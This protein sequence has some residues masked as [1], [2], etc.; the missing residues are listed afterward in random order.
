MITER[1]EYR[2]PK[3]ISDKWNPGEFDP[4]TL[5]KSGLL[6]TTENIKSIIAAET[7]EKNNPE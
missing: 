4:S 3:E 7:N 6:L 1:G 2:I 5:A